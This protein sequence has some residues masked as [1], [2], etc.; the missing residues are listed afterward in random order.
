LL[1]NDGRYLLAT[2][3]AR[4]GDQAG[5]ASLLP[6]QFADGMTGRET[7]DSYASPIRNVALVLSNLVDTDPDNLQIPTLARQ[8][9]EV[10]K[11]ADYLNTQEAAFAFLALGKLAKQNAGSTATA[12]LT[13][14]GKALGTFSGAD[15]ILRRL[16]TGNPLTL[17]TKGSGSLYYFGQS[18]GVP[19][20][21]DVPDEDHGLIVRR[22]YLN[23]DGAPQTRFKQ[24]DLVVVKMT[25]SSQSGLPVK[26]LVLT[27]LLPAGFEVENPRLSGATAQNGTAEQRTMDWIKNPSAVDYFD[28][29]DDRVN[30]Y[31]SLGASETKTVY[32]MVRAVSKGRFVVGPA[33]A[34]A[35]Y[36]PDYRSYNGAGRVV[37]E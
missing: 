34:D 13:A 5:S 36:N 9:S 20:S 19:T 4:L 21:G 28:I 6:K 24:N 2:T 37:V 7:G 29:R 16:P 23:R 31:L 32:Y 30:Y 33:S 22:T 12:T 11:Q 15:I 8:L 27:D 14:A 35:M 1:T 26:N 25:L 3:Y 17:T 18:E 10:V